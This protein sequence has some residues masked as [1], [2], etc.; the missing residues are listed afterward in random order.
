M[1]FV[2]RVAWFSATSLAA[3]IAVNGVYYFF[4]RQD[5]SNKKFVILAST[6]MYIQLGHEVESKIIRSGNSN[7]QPLYYYIITTSGIGAGYLLSE[8]LFL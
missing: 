7:L 8:G 2:G 6:F 3:A 5:I 1:N 4:S